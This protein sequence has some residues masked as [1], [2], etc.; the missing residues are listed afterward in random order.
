MRGPRCEAPKE[1]DRGVITKVNNN[2]DKNIVEWDGDIDSGGHWSWSEIGI[3]P[4]VGEPEVQ[5][6]ELL[7]SYFGF[8]KGDIGTR[9]KV[10]RNHILVPNRRSTSGLS[11]C[12]SYPDRELKPSTKEAYDAQ[13]NKPKVEMSNYVTFGNVPHVYEIEEQDDRGFSVWFHGRTA[14]HEQSIEKHTDARI[15]T[16]DEVIGAERKHD[17]PED[18]KVSETVTESIIRQ[19]KERYPR[20]TKYY[21]LNSDRIVESTGDFINGNIKNCS[22]DRGGEDDIWGL[23]DDGKDEYGYVYYGGEWAEKIGEIYI[24]HAGG[25]RFELYEGIDTI[26]VATSIPGLEPHLIQGGLTNTIE[27][28]ERS[29]EQ[30]REEGKI[31]GLMDSLLR[32]KRRDSSETRASE[33]QSIIEEDYRED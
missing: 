5:Y 1:F 21:A 4:E 18:K 22:D 31:D 13:H 26:I 27:Q 12:V 10:Y 8:K 3:V 32:S 11:P 24:G 20:G 23:D 30:H 29:S 33:I 28:D 6:V 16:I 14:E 15:A 25:E 9:G 2:I 7:A 17:K 19:A